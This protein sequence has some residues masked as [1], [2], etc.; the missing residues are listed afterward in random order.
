MMKEKDRG[1]VD[2]GE[3]STLG[4]V[5]ARLGASEC[6]AEYLDGEKGRKLMARHVAVLWKY[7][8]YH[9]NI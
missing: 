6:G 4:E 5:R 9:N 8:P 3:E 1:V 2:H 7:V